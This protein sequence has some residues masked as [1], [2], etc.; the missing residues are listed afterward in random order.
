[1]NESSRSPGEAVLMEQI[2]LIS[3][4]F[5]RSQSNQQLRKDIGLLDSVEEANTESADGFG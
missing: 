2:E 1:M 3:E 5:K 4:D